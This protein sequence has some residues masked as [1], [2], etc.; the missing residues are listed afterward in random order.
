MYSTKSTHLVASVFNKYLQA[1]ILY[2]QLSRPL[3]TIK[4]YGQNV[5]ININTNLVLTKSQELLLALDKLVCLTI[6]KRVVS[7]VR[8]ILKVRKRRPASLSEAIDLKRLT[9]APAVALNIAVNPKLESKC[10]SQTMKLK[11]DKV[12]V[13][14]DALKW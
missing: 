7:A 9:K 1:P 8:S 4:L 2:K 3:P 10:F 14:P 6:P 5:C 13:P 12:A 11:W